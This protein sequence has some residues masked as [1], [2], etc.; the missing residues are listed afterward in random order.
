[1]LTWNVAASR[2]VTAT[3]SRLFWTVY[4]RAG[5]LDLTSSLVFDSVANWDSNV[6]QRV[7]RKYLYKE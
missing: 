3:K 4:S 1:M 6:L 2:Y 5:M 7:S